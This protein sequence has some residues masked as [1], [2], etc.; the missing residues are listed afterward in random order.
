M[1]DNWEQVI[2]K[3][4]DNFFIGSTQTCGNYMLDPLL[5]QLMFPSHPLE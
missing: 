1:R 5:L 4:L 2:A 3:F